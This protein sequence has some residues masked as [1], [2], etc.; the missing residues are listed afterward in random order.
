[1]HDL[2]GVCLIVCFDYIKHYSKFIN[3]FPLYELS[4]RHAVS[5]HIYILFREISVAWLIH[6]VWWASLY[7][8]HLY[9]YIISVFN[10]YITQSFQIT[11]FLS[12]ELTTVIIQFAGNVSQY[13]VFPAFNHH[14]SSW[15]KWISCCQVR[16]TLSLAFW[17]IS[18][19]KIN[20]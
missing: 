1:M 15:N 14:L 11:F 5:I 8:V 18:W 3:L 12:K 6:F 20:W 17:V 16:L 4:H 13:W 10:S 7:K 19:Q 2:F 9:F